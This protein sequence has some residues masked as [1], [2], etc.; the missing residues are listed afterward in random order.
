M[1]VGIAVECTVCGLRKKPHG[2]SAPLEM[3]NS[4]CDPECDGYQLSPYPGCLWPGETDEDYGFR[5][6]DNATTEREPT[7]ADKGAP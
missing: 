1:K 6:C 3:A 5:S 2:R 4:L 7:A